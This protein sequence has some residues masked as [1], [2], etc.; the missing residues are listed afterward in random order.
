M[1]KTQKKGVTLKKDLMQKVR[2][3]VDQFDNIYVLHFDKSF[4]TTQIQEIRE[5]WKPHG[6]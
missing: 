1:T 3:W 6:R 5:Q 4:K 2:D